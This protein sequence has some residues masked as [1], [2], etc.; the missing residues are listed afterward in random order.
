MTIGFLLPEGDA[1][2]EDDQNEQAKLDASAEP[3]QDVAD[4]EQPTFSDAAPELAQVDLEPVLDEPTGEDARCI[5]VLQQIWAAKRNQEPCDKEFKELRYILRNTPLLNHFQPELLQRLLAA[6]DIDTVPE[7]MV[8]ELVSG[9]SPLYIVLVGSAEV[10][11]MRDSRKV[12]PMT[13]KV[14]GASGLPSEL[15]EQEGAAAVIITRMGRWMWRTPAIMDGGRNPVF[16]WSTTIQ[17]AGEEDIEFMLVTDEDAAPEE[18]VATAVLSPSSFER[19]GFDGVIELSLPADSR[20]G[21]GSAGRL[22]VCVQVKTGHQAQT[23][24]AGG[25]HL[26]RTAPTTKFSQLE[27]ISPTNNKNRRQRFTSSVGSPTTFLAEQDGAGMDQ[28]PSSAASS[29][30][31]GRPRSSTDQDRIV[32]AKAVKRW[33]KMCFAGR[34][35]VPAHCKGLDFEE[36]SEGRVPEVAGG[37][38]FFGAEERH[39]VVRFTRS[40]H[41][42]IVANHT[43]NELTQEMEREKHREQVAFL[44]RWLPGAAQLATRTLEGFA[45]MFQHASFPRGHTLS[46]AGSGGEVESRRVILI[47][48]GSCRCILPSSQQRAR[49]RE[50]DPVVELLGEGSLVGYASSLFG[51]PEPFTVIADSP[52][53]FM[54]LSVRDRPVSS[55]P[56]EVT[57]TLYDVLRQK[58]DWY[59]RRIHHLLGSGANRRK[60]G[61]RQSAW[62]LSESPFLRHKTLPAW[63][64]RTLQD[65]FEEEAKSSGPP[66]PR[67]ASMQP[68]QFLGSAAFYRTFGGASL[69]GSTVS[70]P[71]IRPLTC[72]SRES[73]AL[74]LSSAALSKNQARSSCGFGDTHD[75]M[76]MLGARERQASDWS[77]RADLAA[78]LGDPVQ[79]SL[80]ATAN[81]M[82]KMYRPFQAQ[83]SLS[84][85]SISS[86]PKTSPREVG[87][88]RGAFHF[89]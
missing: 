69:L 22:S 26:L 21:V 87:V 57:H 13:V 10:V 15:F 45:A 43:Y 37:G 14:E 81:S 64:E 76:P 9:H 49:T 48:S 18:A 80:L 31:G 4:E 6:A 59:A 53:S 66:V 58:L 1:P 39:G 73:R 30:R 19:G 86:L 41:V 34:F 65:L 84:E 82:R 5:R 12:R 75:R 70:L 40:S 72:S 56:R 32:H 67:H 8:M 47:K 11:R 7:G 25:L 89:A 54:W 36:M 79:A 27:D 17:H 77:S 35:S 46:S 50:A 63:R 38:A 3:A 28:P 23:S 20:Y 78:K 62:T 85:P 55:W 33:E 24:S 29:C 51:L 42:L 60:G 68:P 16:D 61:E 52:V 88:G 74:P 2:E 44:R 83:S 71:D